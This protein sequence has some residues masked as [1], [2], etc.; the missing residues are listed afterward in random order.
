MVVTE[1]TFVSD[2]LMKYSYANRTH[3]MKIIREIKLTMHQLK[4]SRFIVANIIMIVINL[5]ARLE[6]LHNYFLSLF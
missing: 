2:T 4:Y 6:Q 3:A 5:A 1:F